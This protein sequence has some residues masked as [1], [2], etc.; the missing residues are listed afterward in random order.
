MVG[1]S[2]YETKMYLFL[3]TNELKQSPILLQVTPQLSWQQICFVEYGT[4]QCWVKREFVS[5]CIAK[6]ELLDE[7]NFI[8]FNS[9]DKV[10][11]IAVVFIWDLIM[12]AFSS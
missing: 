3:I 7:K 2:T 12:S 10:S 6:G 4:S 9:E 11:K 8:S 1:V 5:E